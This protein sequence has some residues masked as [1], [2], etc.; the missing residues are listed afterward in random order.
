MIKEAIEF[1]TGLRPSDTPIQAEERT[2]IRLGDGR[3]EEVRPIT[4]RLPRNVVANVKVQD[5]ES[6]IQYVRNYKTPATRVF[7]D[8]RNKMV[9]A[10]IDYHDGDKP[11]FAEHRAVFEMKYSTEWTRWIS[12]HR[13]MIPQAEFAEMLEQNISDISKPDAAQLFDIVS[14]IEGKKQITFKSGYRASDGTRR[15]Q[16]EEDQSASSGEMAIP[17]RIE[18]FIPVFDL[19]ERERVE[20]LLRHR[21]VEGKLM[22]RLDF[23]NHENL[24]RDALLAMKLSVGDDLECAV[25]LG[26]AP[27]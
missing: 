15:I 4:K 2:F 10:V 1:V 18:F 3:L 21:I 12:L 16:F 19:G 25:H 13:K 24:E 6:L 27:G 23:V 9:S 8:V 7:F 5:L 11:G 26:Q 17:G 14:T 22:F 20:A